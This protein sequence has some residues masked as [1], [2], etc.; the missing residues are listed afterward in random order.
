M[1]VNT[2]QGY[3][4]Y[5][6]A[7]GEYAKEKKIP[8]IENVILSQWTFFFD[9]EQFF[10]NQWYT[11]A[12]DGPVDVVLNEDLENFSNIRILE[13]LSWEDEAINESKVFLKKQGYQIVLLDFYYLNSFN[14]NS[15]KRFNVTREHDPHF[16]VLTEIS[17]GQAH[18]TDPF[19][20]HKEIMPVED[21]MK[22]R[23][24]LTKQ[25]KIRFNSYEIVCG[26]IRR[27]NIKEL[28]YYRF[29]RYLKEKM[30]QKIEE[31]A[32]TVKN[33]PDETD[34][35][36]SFTGYNC[37]NSI[38]YQHQN[39]MKIYKLYDFNLPL[40]LDDLENTWALIRKKLFEYYNRGN[41]SVEEISNSI[42]NAAALEKNFAEGVVKS[43]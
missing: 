24:S 18:V 14:W 26:D 25:G 22:A 21:F 17:N 32:V 1:F 30:Y 37:L 15:L 8:E 38:I 7:V 9:K 12:A 40:G 4:C 27:V 29:S 19:Y 13:H 35:K 3:N 5:S 2:F 41:S 16:V 23:S 6:S 20:H 31:F 33:Q 28:L 11:G 39:L 34:R 43:L 42:L 36:W 10:K